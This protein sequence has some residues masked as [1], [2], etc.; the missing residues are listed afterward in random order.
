[1]TT[2]VP[3]NRSASLAR[4]L[5]PMLVAAGAVSLAQVPAQSPLL[6]KSGTGVPP[7]IMLTMDDSGS[8]AFQH[9]PES[10]FASDTFSTA[11]PVNSRTV[12]W[13]PN[14]NYNVGTNFSGTIPGNL[15]TT[16]WVAKAMRSP[17]TNT[18]FYNPEIRYQPWFNDDGV[19]RRPNSPAN[20][21][22]E[23]PPLLA[24]TASS[25]TSLAP[26]TGSKVLTLAQ[27]GKGF[28]VGQNVI[29]SST[30]AP[31]TQW[32]V[33][34]ITAF[35]AGTGSMTVN[36]TSKAGGP[37]ALSS[38][39][40]VQATYVN[41]TQYVAPSGSSNWCYAKTSTAS[42]TGGGCE[43]LTN[44]S[45]THDPGVY[46]R[47]QRTF[48]NGPFKAVNAAGNYTGYSINS[49]GPFTKFPARA[50]CAGA[51]CTQAEERQ[52]YANWFTYYR[53][54]NLLARGS[55]M[56]AFAPEANTFRMGFGR[57]NKG[58]SSVDGVNTT[59]IENS[60]T[61]GGGGVRAFTAPRKVNLFKWLE[62]LPA[63]G[64]TP[65][66]TAMKAIGDYYSR[67]DNRGPYTDD[68]STT[69]T[70]ADNKTCRRSFHIM[71]TDGYWNGAA[72]SV[73]NVD[74]TDGPTIVGLGSSYKYLKSRPFL[75]SNSNSLADVAMYYWNHDLQPSI[76]NA[77]TPVG[78]NN[79]FWQNMTNFTVGL[80]VRGTLNPAT[81]LSALTGGTLN[82]PAVAADSGPPNVDDLWHAAVNSRG[83]FFSAKDPSELASGIKT[84]LAAV[85]GGTGSNSGVATASTVLSNTNRK[86][87]PTFL[88]TIWSGDI[89]AITLDASGQ[90]GATMWKAA[91]RMPAW[92]ARNIVTWDTGLSTPAGAVFGA[93][94]SAGNK[95]A[96]GAFTAPATTN[97]FIDFLRGDHSQE[98]I[99]YPYRSRDNINGSPFILGDFVNANPVLVQNSFNGMYNNPAWGGANGYA[100]FLN[101]KAGRTAVLFAGSNDGMLHGFK[102]SRAA[103]P[104][105]ALTDGQ[106]VFA[107]VPRAVYG[108]LSKLADKNYG[109]LGLPHQYFVDGPL[110]ESDAFVKAPGASTASWRNYLT[111]SLGAGGRAVFALD[112]TDLAN[113]G[114]S[115]VRWEISDA[116]DADL[117]YVLSAIKV[118]VLPNGKWVAIFGNGFSS[119]NG[120]ATLFVVDL[121]TAAIQKLNVDTGGSNG[122]GGV[123]LVHDSAGYISTVY[124]GDLKGKMWKLAYDASAASKFI[125]SGGAAL[126]AATDGSG[127][128]QPITSSPSIFAHSLGGQVVVFGTGKL[129]TSADADDVST[130]SIYGV[131][132]KAG[133]T[134]TRPMS[135]SNLVVRTLSTVAGTGAATGSTFYSFTSSAVNP[136]TNRGWYTDETSV[137]TGGRVIYPTQ[138]DSFRT[139]LVSTVAP[140]QGTPAVCATGSGSGVNLVFPVEPDYISGA[141]GAIPAGIGSGT[142]G[143]QFD[144]NGDGVVNSSDV[145]VAGY[146]TAA[147]GIDAIVRSQTTNGVDAVGGAG[148][149]GSQGDC[150][151]GSLCADDTTV[152][153]EVP[154]CE[155]MCLDVYASANSNTLKCRLRGCVPVPGTTCCVNK[156][157]VAWAGSIC[158]GGIVPPR[159]YDRIWRRIINPPI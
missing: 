76:D 62:D 33:G 58:S 124:A 151:E 11:N 96:L 4:F 107:Y 108:N 82:W 67:T 32:M 112:V 150:G 128:A 139:A 28:T 86:Y 9:M 111:G 31:T 69:N 55:I 145:V 120:Y 19:T 88:P 38:W 39:T 152:C 101:T 134:I 123:T 105:S 42:A 83:K 5:L 45:V 106:E 57:I 131:W 23:S 3:S 94:M 103:T 71:M 97:N 157:P 70:V 135:R 140:V 36:V 24:R 47:L 56:E 29:I 66:V 75:D 54:R 53:N 50:D 52:N 65:L 93:S 15:A 98:G 100:T 132:D 18:V 63:S 87:V 64:G 20:T 26:A 85:N 90:S 110:G 147:D 72:V 89:S 130:Q 119:S 41:L 156:V 74:N 154:A 125:V 84:A 80:G 153:I 13:D 81:D 79:S 115:S 51:S 149:G 95:T 136:A 127:T 114:P 116:N 126:F 137:I 25:T 138:V 6:T 10:V 14:D 148:G 99:G 158:E 159:T 118:G 142:A 27:T 122:L 91:D 21:A 22:Y 60:S 77:V 155:G 61:Y 44:S 144:T 1:M 117:G 121:E 40:V 146:K 2:C 141:S 73:G 102:D 8:M 129:F 59:V 17:D 113:L 92:N 48:T 143:R 30:A 43:S 104:L 16:N 12:I 68:P 133:D 49:A 7:N 35:N 34:S 78:D 37:A 46:F 109:S